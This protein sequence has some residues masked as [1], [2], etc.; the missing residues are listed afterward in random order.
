MT[1][2]KQKGRPR[3]NRVAV[4][5]RIDREVFDQFPEGV[6]VSKHIEGII[7]AYYASD[8]VREMVRAYSGKP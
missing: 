3:T 1:Q 8:A 4:Q 6:N 7:T 2:E 5:S